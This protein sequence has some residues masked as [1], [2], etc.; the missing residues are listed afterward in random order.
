MASSTNS[1]STGDEP[2]RKT[3][4]EQLDEAA[5]KAKNPESDSQGGIVNAVLEKGMN[6]TRSFPGLSQN[7]TD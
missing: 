1:P 6:V 2:Q 3:Y 7:S 4:K 5:I